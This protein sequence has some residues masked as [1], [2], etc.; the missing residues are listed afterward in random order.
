MRGSSVGCGTKDAQ[1]RDMRAGAPTTFMWTEDTVQNPVISEKH[2]IG[3]L[4][5]ERGREEKGV[6]PVVDA[7][8]AGTGEELVRGRQ[9]RNEGS[10]FGQVPFLTAGAAVAELCSL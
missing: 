10:G 6:N 9:C 7:Y 3:E 2:R 1:A 8:T 5:V 4:L